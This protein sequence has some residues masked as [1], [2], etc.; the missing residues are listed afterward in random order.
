MYAATR[1]L[2]IGLLIAGMVPFTPFLT[3]P[4]A[5]LDWTGD[6]SITGVQAYAGDT[7]SL[8]G[9]LD[10]SGTLSF[11]GVDLAVNCPANGSYT[12]TVLTGGTF[13]VLQGSK[14]HSSN[15]GARFC[16]IVQSGATLQ[17]DKSTLEDCGYAAG[18]QERRG[19]SLQSGAASVTDSVLTNNCNGVVV[20]GQSSPTIYRNNI[21]SN[22]QSGVWV[23]DGCAPV[24]DR[25]L[26]FGN[27]R[28]VGSAGSASAGIYGQA[29]SP[30]I[31]NNTISR[32]LDLTSKACGTGIRLGTAAAVG[33]PVISRNDIV[34]HNDSSGY[35][36]YIDN[37]DAYILLNNITNN[38][39]GAWI[40]KGSSQ[41]DGNRFQYNL[42]M[43][44][45][46]TGYSIRDGGHSTYSVNS[47]AY[48]AIGIYLGDNS[49]S[50]F[51]DCSVTYMAVSGVGG[52]TATV[53]FSSTFTN[54]TFS[55]NS[56]D[57]LFSSQTTP[58]TGGT[59]FLVNSTHDPAKL[60]ITD[61]DAY[62][63]VSWNMRA[64]VT[65]ETGATPASGAKVKVFD[66]KAAEQYT[67]LADGNGYTP[68]I[69]LEQKTQSFKDNATRTP[70]N[71]TG[72]KGGLLNW[73]SVN[74][75]SSRTV[76]VI[77]D[78][79]WPTLAI[80]DPSNG[81]VVNRTYAN[82]T[83]RASP[84]ATVFVNNVA[85]KPMGGGAWNAA[86]NLTREGP[87]E[88]R[89]RANDGGRNEVAQN[90][91]LLRDINAPTI[92]ISTPAD[93]ALVNTT[94]LRLIG[95]VS[96]TSGVTTINGIAAA[97]S[98]DGAFSV[99][100][101]L[102]EGDNS[103]LIECRDA[104][105][106][107]A[108]LLRTVTLDSLAPD[109]VVTEPESPSIVTNSTSTVIRGFTEL[110]ASMTM[111]GQFLKVN[112]T[113]FH[114]VVGLV[115]GDNVFVFVASD[116]AGNNKT[117]TVR[118]MR[119]T[120]PPPLMI[121]SP[122]DNSVTNL[123]TLEIRGVAEEGALV[124]VNG[125]LATTFGAEYKASVKLDKQGRNTIRVEA[126]DML[127]NRAEVSI[128]VNLDTVPPELKVTAPLNNYLTN[129]KSVEIRGRTEKGAQL[130]INERPVLPDQNGVFAVSMGL[131]E[132]GPNL[133]DV[134][135]RDPAGNVAQYALTVMRDTELVR[136][137][138]TPKEGTKQTSATILVIGVTEANATV[139]VNG[140][141]VTLRPDRTFI[142]EVTLTKGKNLITVVFTDKAGNSEAVTVNVTR[143]EVKPPEKGFIPGFTTVASL[144]AAASAIVA[145]GW[146]RRK[147]Y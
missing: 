106:N 97:V 133:F 44:A 61:T 118:I 40:G 6:Q 121:V 94:P 23:E 18:T 109:L 34:G 137:V 54:C 98:P 46:A 30:V 71:V 79:S 115:E 26:I 15:P 96:E 48:G 122:K 52:D 33:Y 139:S 16:F 128:Y 78:D 53:A 93:R 108:S 51:S 24:I 81:T 1:A 32:N 84:L 86:V 75:D 130:T 107:T 140:K 43:T 91:T 3:S 35:G 114:A 143:T 100:V 101:D 99:D 70:Y 68:W 50:Q 116:K 13:N 67:F 104:V 90:I 135:S 9:N 129:G 124:K 102:H 60:I 25:N 74:L 125:V 117:A 145:A 20:M 31:T 127:A 36:V 8:T 138:T 142:S 77:L 120:T 110:N 27:Q 19:L 103:M 37:C 146:T 42:F 131:S 17:F 41:V 141:P 55:D 119:D 113:E 47:V 111:N 132:E 147:R 14:I 88:F 64:R 80:D 22:D 57:I 12:I 76:A 85:A 62:V 58:S 87:N 136:S 28:M 65:V 82:I 126:W 72:E 11:T 4:A 112:D 69:V 73:T 63:K 21:S 10:V 92:I 59:A 144:A 123:S 105:W 29:C 49:L 89:I 38:G 5:A 45:P 7:I 134:Q 2:A 56:A 95:N 83:G 39:N 66:K